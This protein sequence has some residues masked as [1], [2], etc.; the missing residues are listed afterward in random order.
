L[1]PSFPPAFNR[2]QPHF[3]SPTQLTDHVGCQCPVP[4]HSQRPQPRRR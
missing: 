1:L 2:P 3:L 4:E